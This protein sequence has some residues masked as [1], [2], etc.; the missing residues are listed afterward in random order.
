M[1]AR[2]G[3]QFL[4]KGVSQM[5]LRQWL[6]T[7]RDAG[8]LRLIENAH[9]DLEIGGITTLNWKKK[10]PQAL[11]FD[12]IPGYP[13][14]FRVAA[15]TLA[16]PRR[17]AIALG[18]PSVGQT[19]E[20]VDILRKRWPA[21][22]SQSA[23]YEPEIVKGSLWNNLLAGGDVDLLRFP[24]PRWHE[25][26][27]GRYLGTGCAVITR[28]PDDGTVNS[29]VYRSMVHDRTTA[30]LNMEM[31]K[32]GRIHLDKYHGKGQPCPIAISIGHHPLHLLI[33]A[34]S[35]PS[36]REHRLAGAIMGRPLKLVR[37]EVT[38]LPVPADS[39]I[40]VAGFSPPSRLENEG[41]FGEWVGYYV[42]GARKRHV[43]EVQ[44][45]YYRDSPIILGSPPGKAP[46]DSSYQGSVLRSAVL[47]NQLERLGIPGIHAVWFNETGGRFLV[48][49]AIK[50]LY[51]GHARQIAVLAS[52]LPSGAAFMGRWI[53]VTDDDIDVTDI[54]QVLW[55]LCTRVDPDKDIDVFRRCW[56]SSIDPV[57]QPPSP[58]PTTSRAII[59]A[60]KPFESVKDF[61]PEIKLS[62]ELE[63]KLK[64]KWAN[65]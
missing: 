8:E 39:E 2:R 54:D 40:V 4:M 19:P 32:H 44:R 51:A 33:G 1:S 9:C 24:A 57:V 35:V 10:P 7:V 59:D 65:L 47:H 5:D 22:E 53:I 38:G 17:L 45:I 62:A 42:S 37:E 11:L 64:A 56:S 41:P 20:L 43:V 21:W 50:Q 36:G 52:Q 29:G 61:P 63:K 3:E 55:A 15:S 49:I 30:C 58:T 60:C 46:A 14:G 34:L 23:G 48:A 13:P 6:D 18:F 31:G 28:D 25:Q 12:N 27:G 16:S 26:D